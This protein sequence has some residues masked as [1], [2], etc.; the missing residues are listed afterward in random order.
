M[1]YVSLL[2]GAPWLLSSDYKHQTGSSSEPY[3]LAL[4]ATTP[5]ELQRIQS[6]AF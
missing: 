3:L 4:P 5:L 1:E 2:E 6:T